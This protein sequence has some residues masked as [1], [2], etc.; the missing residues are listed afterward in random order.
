[1]IKKNFEDIIENISSDSNY[2]VVI[3]IGSVIL[4]LQLWYQ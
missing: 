4:Y 2:I 3:V 1:M